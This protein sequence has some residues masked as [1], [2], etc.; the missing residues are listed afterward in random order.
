ME[1]WKAQLDDV[2]EQYKGLLQDLLSRMVPSEAAD[3]VYSDMRESF[4]AA[5][6]SLMSNPNLLWQT[7]SR[8]VQ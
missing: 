1:T 4:E 7:Q 6:Q 3:S 8:L 5:A 2:G